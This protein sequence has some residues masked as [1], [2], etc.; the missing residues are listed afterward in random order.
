MY[1][2][3]WPSDSVAQVTSAMLQKYL[4]PLAVTYRG[5]DHE[6]IYSGW[7]RSQIMDPTLVWP[8]HNAVYEAACSAGCGETIRSYGFVTV[9]TVNFAC[10]TAAGVP[11]T[12]RLYFGMLP[13]RST[14]YPVG[15]SRCA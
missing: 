9:R 6:S 14:A 8:T 2:A 12:E 3:R 7:M 1:D 10:E 11:Y 4:R 13:C 15:G 5:N